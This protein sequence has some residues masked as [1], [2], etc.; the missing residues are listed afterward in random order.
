METYTHMN[1]RRSYR[2]PY[3]LS[4]DVMME[5]LDPITGARLKDVSP[6]GM[7]FFSWDPVT[8][9]QPVNLQLKELDASLNVE[10]NVV[11]CHHTA[12]GRFE[13]G[14]AIASEATPHF[15]NAY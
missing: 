11:R 8:V 7:C 1:R 3:S 5:E 10:G 14:V 9:G 6:E 12:S 4:A 13:V 15:K 2:T